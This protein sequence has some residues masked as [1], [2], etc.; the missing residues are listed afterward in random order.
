MLNDNDQQLLSFYL[1]AP[2]MQATAGQVSFALGYINAGAVNLHVFRLAKK[3]AGTFSYKPAYLRNGQAVWWPCLFEGYKGSQGFVWTLKR[4]VADWYV[5]NYAPD[6]FYEQ[7]KAA[8]MDCAGRRRRLA[9]APKLPSKRLVQQWVFVR[10]PDV[11]AEVLDRARGRCE[12]CET[13]A[14][15]LRRSDGLPYLEVHHRTHLAQ[16]G[17]DTVENA[18]GLCPNCHREAHYG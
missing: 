16:G 4:E 7:V 1:N 5:A 13:V 14:P 10:N 8:S 2:S 17:E 6:A 9:V 15:F 11:V 3:V 12:G 18:I